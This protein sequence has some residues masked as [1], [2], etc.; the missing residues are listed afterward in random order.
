ME[1]THAGVGGYTD[2]R[3][4]WRPE[5]PIIFAPV[6]TW[7]P[8]LGKFLSWLLNYLFTWNLI[9]LGV[10]MLSYYFLQPPL[11]EMKVLKVSWIST[12]FI[13]NMAL[14]WIVAGGWHLYLYTFKKRGTKAK[15]CPRWQSTTGS[16]FLWN[17]QVYDN[18]FWTCVSGVPIW[19]AFEALSFWLYAN[20]KLPYL[21]L[22]EHP[23]YFILI[24]LL[25]PFWREFHFYLIHRLIHWKPL[26]NRIH[27][28]HHYNINPGP[29]S[30]LS[31]HPLEH[32]LYFT[33]MLVHWI[34]P[35]HP[36]HLLFNSQHA[37]LTPAPG[38]TGFE[39]K[40][41]KFLPFGSY[42]HY[43]HH[44][45]FECNYGEVTIPMDK[46]FGIFDD[47]SLTQ[48]E[49][50]EAA[51]AYQKLRV[52]KII[53]ES[54]EVKSFYL[55]AVDDAELKQSIPGQHLI[56]RFPFHDKK[57][58][59][60]VDRADGSQIKYALRSYTISNGEKN[61]QYRIS[62]KNEPGGHVSPALHS[63]LK[64]GDVIEAKGP[65]GLFVLQQDRRKP[66]VFIAAGIGITPILSMLKSIDKTNAERYLIL[67]AK[68]ENLLS[69]KE[70]IHQICKDHPN[71]KV[72][73]F[74]SRKPAVHMNK[75]YSSWQYHSQRL[76]PDS[77][78]AILPHKNNFS[79]YIC[80]PEIMTASL[81]DGI[82]SW[83]G[84]G[85]AI[86]TE[87]FGT[88]KKSKNQLDL[89]KEIQVHFTKSDITVAW[90][91]EYANILEF[92]ESNGVSLEAGCMFGEC[93]ACSTKMEKGSVDYN[94]QTAI[95]PV[96]GNCLPCS[97]FPTSDI[98]LEG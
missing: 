80:G 83:K 63:S 75:E 61:D 64:V 68:E 53:D 39:G 60:D 79:F 92:A 1:K 71:I 12:I 37:A 11:E 85:S 46:W 14:I 10:V 45:L 77:L 29:W 98:R 35:S 62:V 93:G 52:S 90:D 15:Y 7:P 31:M 17:N 57:L 3:G 51:S 88:Q 66:A 48:T 34:I 26:Y 97:C 81:M 89:N 25:I 78:K 49:K 41:G 33:T 55:S 56:F 69:F 18:I 44:R 82:K 70:E 16:T 27:Y 4:E 91:H 2:S 67:A 47:G 74:F 65:K 38:H 30:G 43:L 28:L 23:F 20:G 54:P 21:D 13:R 59:P 5:K 19:T 86:H 94:Y 76:D 24:F 73:L 95:K 84:I 22:R 32:L 40:L 8:K 87:S 58:C 36:L 96:Q 6:F 50:F 72:H 9:Y 42:F